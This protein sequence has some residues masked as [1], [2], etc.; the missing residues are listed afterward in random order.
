MTA[1]LAEILESNSMSGQDV[2]QATQGFVAEMS[3]DMSPEDMRIAMEKAAGSREV[4]KLIESLRDSEELLVNASLLALSAAWN[5]EGTQ[6]VVRDSLNYSRDK[7]PLVEVGVASIAC[8][9][10]IYLVVTKGRKKT[11]FE[12]VR[13]EDGS[14]R[15][16][17]IHEYIQLGGVFGALT[18]LFTGSGPDPGQGQVENEVSP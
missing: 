2:V 12:V 16:T 4:R 3:P 15:V 10:A 6:Q 8:V 13:H 7:M 5:A 18:S 14:F 17:E 11:T 1:E 9:Y